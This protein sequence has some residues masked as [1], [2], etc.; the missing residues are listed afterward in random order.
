MIYN[1]ACPYIEG[2]PS[3][4]S[5]EQIQQPQGRETMLE[6]PWPYSMLRHG[7][8]SKLEYPWRYNWAP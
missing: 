4:S 7:L 6:G 8:V 3:P 5:R 2:C 1:I